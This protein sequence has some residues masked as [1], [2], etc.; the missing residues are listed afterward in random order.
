MIEWRTAGKKIYKK[1]MGFKNDCACLQSK[2][3]SQ[4]VECFV[5]SNMGNIKEYNET[6]Q[7]GLK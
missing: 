3:F 2:M 1:Q 6:R 5:Q 7:G 4:S